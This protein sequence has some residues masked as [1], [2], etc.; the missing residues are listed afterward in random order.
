[1]LL[2][3]SQSGDVVEMVEREVDNPYAI[4]LS[5]LALKGEEIEVYLAKK[6]HAGAI[7]TDYL[8]VGGHGRVIDFVSTSTPEVLA[9]EFA[10]EF[11]QEEVNFYVARLTAV[12]RLKLLAAA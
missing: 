11:A 8:F 3:V 9:V 7:E 2:F 12:A 6:T 4:A 1:M 10:Q 5:L